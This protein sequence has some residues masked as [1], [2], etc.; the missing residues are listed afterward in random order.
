MTAG[1]DVVGL[2]ELRQ[3]VTTQLRTRVES[4][5]R[6]RV[7]A[8]GG[9]EPAQLQAG[10]LARAQAMT[11]FEIV[12]GALPLALLQREATQAQE[13]VR[14]IRMLLQ[15][16]AGNR[17]RFARAVA[18]DAPRTGSPSARPSACAGA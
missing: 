5:G 10:F 17:Q 3:L 8:G 12:A 4:R 1:Q 16:A 2:R 6:G 15:P 18:R 9:E 13:Q 14:I 11:A 7:L